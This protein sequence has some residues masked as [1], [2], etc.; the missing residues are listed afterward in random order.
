MNEN[1]HRHSAGGIIFNNGKVLTLEWTNKEG[2][3]FPKGT[4]NPG[5]A[6][7]AAAL[8][9]VREE[10]GYDTKIIA[11]LPQIEYSFTLADGKHYHK[12]VDFYVM[13][14][15]N[16]NEPQPRREATETFENLW[17]GFDEAMELLTHDDSKE[18]LKQAIRIVS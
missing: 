15:A 2:I 3:E 9:E 5:E 16:D 14:L 8:R 12:V 7:E 13:E 11:A 17:L 10:T 18:L 4:L 1:R 6:S